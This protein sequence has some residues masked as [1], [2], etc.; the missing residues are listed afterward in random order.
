MITLDE[1][2][3]SMRE[4]NREEAERYYPWF[5]GALVEF[6]IIDKKEIAYFIGQLAHESM[7][8]TYWEEIWGPTPTQARYGTRADL[9]NTDP[10][11]KEAATKAGF[12]DENGFVDVGR[13]FSGHGPIQTTGYANHKRVAEKLNIDCVNKP[14]LL[15]EPEYGFRA[16]CLFWVDNKCKTWVEKDDIKGLTRKINGGFNGL[17][18]RIARTEKALKA[19]G[20]S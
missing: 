5:N 17:E 6:N 7:G 13:F 12:V 18:D 14:R 19:L 8:L 9:G 10:K 2:Y 1:F 3:R 11:A 15:C 20:V 4:L 16:A